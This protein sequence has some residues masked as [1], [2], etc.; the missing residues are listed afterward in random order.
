M[1][2]LFTAQFMNI[3]SIYMTVNKMYN[4]YNMQLVK[5]YTAYNILITIYMACQ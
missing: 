1:I 3:Y 2:V 4:N 5:C